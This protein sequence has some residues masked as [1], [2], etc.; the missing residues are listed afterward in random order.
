MQQMLD[1]RIRDDSFVVI[2]KLGVKS[3]K[4]VENINLLHFKIWVDHLKFKK[5]KYFK[6]FKHL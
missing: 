3:S 2:P 5:N 6:E 4:I 1:E